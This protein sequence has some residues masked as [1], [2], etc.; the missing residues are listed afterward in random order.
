M[1]GATLIEKLLSRRSSRILMAVVSLGVLVLSLI[2]RPQEILGPLKL[3]DKLGHLIAYVVLGFL[4]RRSV[5]HRGALPLA[6]TIVACTAFGGVIELVQ[7]M[8]GRTMELADF[9]VDLAGSAV[10]A[11]VG[12]LLRGP[13]AGGKRTP[14]S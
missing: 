11:G 12:A 14:G 6:L 7:P 8:V 1:A 5:G 10:G 3:S 2:P 13:S 9:L 4:A